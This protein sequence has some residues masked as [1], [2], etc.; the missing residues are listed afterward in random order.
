MD[1]ESGKGPLASLLG[2][3]C[4]KL[5]NVDRLFV[6]LAGIGNKE[7]KLARAIRNEM[8]DLRSYARK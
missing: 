1:R 5:E 3:V 2:E 4:E 6:Y 8:R 7:K